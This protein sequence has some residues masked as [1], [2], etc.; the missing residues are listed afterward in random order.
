MQK[1]RRN[2]LHA[3]CRTDRQTFHVSPNLTTNS[4]THTALK[5]KLYGNFF[6]FFMDTLWS[7]I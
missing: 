7:L 2:K 1:P 3:E 5:C 4:A 6:K